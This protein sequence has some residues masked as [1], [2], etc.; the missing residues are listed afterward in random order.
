MKVV[1]IDP[2][3]LGGLCLLGDGRTI[4]E[5][6]RMPVSGVRIGLSSRERKWIDVSRVFELLQRWQPDRVYIE[7]QFP[8]AKQGATSTF[9]T[10]FNYGALCATLMA[11]DLDHTIVQS[12]TWKALLEVT[13]D[14][15]STQAKASQIW[16]AH[17]DKWSSG[18][19]NGLAEAAL[20]A[21]F[22]LKTLTTERREGT[23]GRL[24]NKIRFDDRVISV[25]QPVE[26]RKLGIKPH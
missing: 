14:K 17:A 19:T 7:Q 21:W 24:S 10:A 11:L 9:T 22:G 1:G 12:R 2:G 6:V 5:L 25:P 8:I 13:F 15:R 18:A 4:L 20:I 3:L 23:D 16:P 26:Y